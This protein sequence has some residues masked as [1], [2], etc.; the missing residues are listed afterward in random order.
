M[1]MATWFQLANAEGEK[2]IKN[3]AFIELNEDGG[4]SEKGNYV[5]DKIEGEWLIFW[6]N[7]AS[8]AKTFL[9]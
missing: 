5:N 9:S 7:G 2:N 3:G 1:M 6:P 8:K 4:I